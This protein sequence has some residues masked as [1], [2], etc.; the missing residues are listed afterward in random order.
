MVHNFSDFQ[1]GFISSYKFHSVY[2]FNRPFIPI[3]L[4]FSYAI[5]ELKRQGFTLLSVP[6]LVSK[7]TLL[8]C[9]AP[10]DGERTMVYRL[11][12]SSPAHGKLGYCNLFL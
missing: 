6:D 11:D 5:R 1:Q 12:S 3:K 4:C 9:G 8:S 10:V 7:D 2:C